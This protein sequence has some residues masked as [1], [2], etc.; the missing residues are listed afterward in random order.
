MKKILMLLSLFFA[1]PSFG[2]TVVAN[3]NGTPITDTDI[4]MRTKLMARQ[5]DRKSTRLNSSHA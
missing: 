5:G 4:T 1:L 2:A 3:V